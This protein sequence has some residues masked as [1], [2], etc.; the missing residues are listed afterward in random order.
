MFE[1][2][3]TDCC[4]HFIGCPENGIPAIDWARAHGLD[5]SPNA[6]AGVWTSRSHANFKDE[7]LVRAFSDWA[8]KDADLVLG[9][10]NPILITAEDWLAIQE[11][12]DPIVVDEKNR[13]L[14]MRVIAA[15]RAANP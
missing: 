4:F 13:P 2:D 9:G 5:E 6:K 3:Y 7:L 10:D 14:L 1:I 15:C 12:P 8:N 11:L